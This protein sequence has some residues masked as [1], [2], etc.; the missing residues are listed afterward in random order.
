M[1]AATLV[2]VDEYLHTSYDPDC[3]YVDGALEER[4]LG[5]YNHGRLQ[6][7]IMA[8]LYRQE[9]SNGTRVVIEQRVRTTPTRFRVPDIVVTDGKPAEQVLTVP[10]L[11]CIEAISPEDRL[12]RLTLRAKEYIAM[13]VPEVWI[14]DPETLECYRYTSDGLH[15]IRD[16]ILTT[17]DGRIRLDLDAIEQDLR[18]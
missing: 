7:L 15:E 4:N 12:S 6:G 1:R 3:D 2:S 9:K 17:A 11:L 18:Q 16:R 14:I 5:K 10:P 8:Y 13:G